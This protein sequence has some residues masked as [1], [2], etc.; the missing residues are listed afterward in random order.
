MFIASYAIVDESRDLLDGDGAGFFVAVENLLDSEEDSKR[1]SIITLTSEGHGQCILIQ[2]SS[3]DFD[4]NA[5]EYLLVDVPIHVIQAAKTTGL[6]ITD[7]GTGMSINFKIS[8]H[9]DAPLFIQGSQRSIIP[10][11]GKLLS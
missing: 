2:L 1:Y 4:L 10:H 6:V 9:R 8:K 3:D 5:A 7:F 11:A